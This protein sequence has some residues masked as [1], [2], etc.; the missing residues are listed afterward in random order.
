M[1]SHT[2]YNGCMKPIS[3]LPKK[4]PIT[5]ELAMEVFRRD[6]DC[7]AYERGFATQERC[8]GRAHIHHRR[9]RSQSG[10]NHIE[11]LILLC[12]HHHHLA[13]RVYRSEAE[14]TGLIVRDE[15]WLVG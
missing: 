15:P 12:D 14:E 7:R 5:D 1:P 9:L 6:G 13:H 11:N 10:S 4:V 3:K 2:T 8:N